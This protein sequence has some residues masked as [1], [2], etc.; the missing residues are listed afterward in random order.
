MTGERLKRNEECVIRD[1]RNG[2]SCYKAA[3]NLV[4][5]ILLLSGKQNL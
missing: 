2:N 5:F 4:E 3:L 1:R